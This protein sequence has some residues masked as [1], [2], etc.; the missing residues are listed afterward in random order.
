MTI[1]DFQKEIQE[2]IPTI[3]PELTPYD[4]NVNHAPI[5]DQDKQHL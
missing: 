3:L 2:G 1:N 4:S 5:I